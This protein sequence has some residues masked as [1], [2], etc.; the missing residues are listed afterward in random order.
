MM[1]PGENLKAIQE[2]LGHANIATTANIYGHLS[3]RAKRDAALRLGDA[4]AAEG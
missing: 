4:L 1:G 3:A 2:Q